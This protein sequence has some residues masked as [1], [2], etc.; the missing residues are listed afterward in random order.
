[1]PNHKAPVEKVIVARGGALRGVLITLGIAGIL[2]AV[3][4]LLRNFAST[5]LLIFAGV[6]FGILIDGIARL[7]VRYV[8]LPRPIAIAVTVLVILGTISI[9]FSTAGPQVISQAQVLGRELPQSIAVAENQLQ[10]FRWGRAVVAA[11]PAAGDVQLSAGALVGR[12]SQ[13]LTITAELVGAF[14]F[15]FFVGVYSAAAPQHYI[16][17]ALLLVSREHRPRAREILEA[18]GTALRW[19]LLGRVVTMTLMGT[20]TTL[21]L[22]LLN[23]PLALVLGILAGILLFVPYLGAIAA[24]IPAVLIGLLAS[25][26]KAL[27]VALVYTGVH[28]FEGYC[29]TP[30]VQ[31]RAV[32]LPPALLLSVQ[33]LS[34]A[35]FGLM[36]VIFSTPLT[37]VAIVLIQALYVQDVLGERVELLGEHGGKAKP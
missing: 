17:G 25:P 11:L 33:L 35:L 19:W 23:I 20:L 16:P 36:G 9:F 4:Y 2:L 10:H 18:L 1:M 29:I 26:Q 7:L 37:V 5:L 27:W 32:S 13:A 8:R 12:V 3:L 21:A 14:L 34:A 22:W 30:F 28:I 15:I 31:K 6:L 24:A